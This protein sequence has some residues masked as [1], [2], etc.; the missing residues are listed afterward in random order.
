MFLLIW[1]YKYYS[2]QS[3]VLYISC[4]FGSNS[5]SFY[6]LF[7]LKIVSMCIT[8][9][10]PNAV[11]SV[12]PSQS[13]QKQLF[14]LPLPLYISP[15]ALGPS[16]LVRTSCS[17]L[18]SCHPGNCR[19]ETGGWWLPRVGIVMGVWITEVYALIKT[20][21]RH[22]TFVY[23]IVCKFYVKRREA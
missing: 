22:T 4:N 11:R 20:Q 9:S 17:L 21:Q 12:T 15:G 8:I 18:Q 10:L 14:Y 2:Q 23:L 13:P 16:A 6:F 19:G 1:L 3:H 5:H 7:C